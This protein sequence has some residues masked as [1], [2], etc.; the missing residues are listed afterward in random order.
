[1]GLDS[2]SSKI[3]KAATVGAITAAAFLPTACH[4]KERPRNEGTAPVSTQSTPSGVVDIAVDY[5][6][7]FVGGEVQGLSFKINDAGS[8]AVPQ[9]SSVTA[10]VKYD[11]A[12]ADGRP[13]PRNQVNATVKGATRPSRFAKYTPLGGPGNIQLFN[14]DGTPASP[15][16]QLQING[17]IITI[18]GRTY[19]V[20]AR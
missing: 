3:G 19:K 2:F 4:E 1:M 6:G 20:L 8:I 14:P 15:L 12:G 18:R 10:E 13:V 16:E 7:V 11:E 5:S 9:S 17:G